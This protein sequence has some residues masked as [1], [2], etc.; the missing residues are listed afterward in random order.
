VA[1]FSQQEYDEVGVW[2]VLVQGVQ[3]LHVLRSQS[4]HLT[5]PRLSSPAA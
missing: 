2:W 1:S 4:G 5:E 3:S